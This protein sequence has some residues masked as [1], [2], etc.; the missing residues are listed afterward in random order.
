MGGVLYLTIFMK[1]LKKIYYKFH[2]SSRSYA[3]RLYE[4]IYKRK[5]AVKYIFSGGMATLTNLSVLFILTEVFGIYYLVS[6]V[7]AFIFS[8][9]VSFSMQKFWTFGDSSKENIHKQFAYY[10]FIVLL[11]LVLNTFSVYVFVEYLHL[12]YFIAQFFA[13]VIIAVVSFFAYRNLVFKN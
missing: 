8:I 5:D 7:F 9:I 3:P 4:I 12:W 10:L 11:N 6:S 2:R 1:T 13:G